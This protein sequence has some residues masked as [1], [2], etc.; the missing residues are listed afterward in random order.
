MRS[1]LQLSLLQDGPREVQLLQSVLIGKVCQPFDHL[2]G[3][4]LDPL[5]KQ[6]ICPVL[7][8][9]DLDA[10]LQM[11]PHEGSV[12]NDNHLPAPAGHPSSEAAQDSTGHL[13]CKHTLLTHGKFI[14]YQD[15]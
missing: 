13:G 10:V 11:E 9:S 5:Q 1:S 6:H 12:E 2:P 7:V 3:S 4:P 15:P 14:I 8:A